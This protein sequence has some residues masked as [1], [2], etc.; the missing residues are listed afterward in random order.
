MYTFFCK[1]LLNIVWSRI[2]NRNKSLRFH[3]TDSSIHRGKFRGNH[4]KVK[5]WTCHLTIN[6]PVVY[7]VRYKVVLRGD[8]FGPKWPFKDPKKSRFLGPP[9]L[10][11]PSLWIV[12]PSKPLCT[13]PYK[14]QVHWL[15]YVPAMDI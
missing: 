5:I 8:F 7:K 11:C 15:F 12:P 3:N 10:K 6:V 4:K 14:Q 1:T 2:R 9:S 13:A